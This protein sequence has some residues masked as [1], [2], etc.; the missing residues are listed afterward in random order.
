MR[1]HR[2]VEAIDDVTQGDL[3]RVILAERDDEIGTLAGRFNAMTGSLREAR[4]EISAACEAK[5]ALEARLRQSEKLATIGQ[6]A[7]EIAHEVGTPLNVIGGRARTMEKK[8]GDPAEVAKNAG[9]IA[10][11]TQRI[12]KIIQQL[13][14]FARRRPSARSQVDV[15]RWPRTRSTSSSTSCRQGRIRASL[16]AFRPAC[17]RSSGRSR[18]DPAGLP[19]PVPERDPGHARR[20]HTSRSA[21]SAST[22]RNGRP[23]WP[24]R[25]RLRR[26]RG[27]RHRRRHRARRPREDLRAVLLDQ[28]RTGQGTGLG[29]AVSHGIVKDHDGWIEVSSRPGGGTVFRVHLPILP[30][31]RVTSPGINA[32]AARRR[33]GRADRTAKEPKA[34]A[35]RATHPGRRG[36]RG[37]ARAAARGAGRG[38]LPRRGGPG[39]PRR[40]RARA[41]G[42][43]RS[44]RL[45]RQ[46][47]RPRR[48]R[49]AARDQGGRAVARTSSRSPRSD[50]STPPSAR[51]SW[52]P[53]TTSP[54]RSRSTS[55][56]SS[57]EKALAERELRSEVARL[58]DEVARSYRFDNIIGKSAA[59]QEVFGLIRR[60]AGS[61]A[62]VL[63]TG[64]SGTGKELVA[65]AIHFN[66]PRKARPFVAVNCAAIPDTL[67]ESELFGYKRGAF[68]DA[69]TDRGRPVRRGRRRHHL[70][71]RDRR[72]VAGAAGQAPARAAGARDP[73]ARRDAPR[74]S[75]CA[76]SPR[77]TATSSAGSRTGRSARISTTG[78]T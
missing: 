48:P 2:L 66:S 38:G 53:S 14:D 25:R 49:H 33:G 59:M 30:A 70:P 21:S 69:R 40:R 76:S 58:R 65:R 23:R 20:R 56:C 60:L 10:D 16:G 13:L 64:E 22:A 45:R 35:W 41:A 27:R 73:A 9:I 19:E 62:S 15:G 44:R 24:P 36:R 18:P 51:S 17:R 7:A 29:L 43:H 75:T 46:D 78:S 11:Q 31:P 61:S 71:R 74:R 50:R 34:G 54:S 1:V 47:A 26:P 3:S 37:H 52:A 68:T 12:T 77:P 6:M 63:V 28:G 5:L 39:R 42:R 72:A 57:V 8:A 55:C 32:V 67:L 4:E